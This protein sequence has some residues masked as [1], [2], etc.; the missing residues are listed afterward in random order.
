[1]T[2]SFRPAIETI[3]DVAD[4][5]LKAATTPL[6][7]SRAQVGARL[8]WF[9]R[10]PGRFAPDVIT[11]LFAG[12][13]KRLDRPPHLVVDPFAGTGS[14]MVVARQLGVPS[15]GIELSHLGTLVAQ[16]RLDP[17][18]HPQQ[19][20]VLAEAWARE[21][22]GDGSI[23][24]E[25]LRSWL[26]ESNTTAVGGYLGRIKEVSD[27]RLARLMTLAVSAALRPS[28]RWLPGSIK[29]QIAKDRTCPPIGPNLVRA[30]R[31]L[32]RDC[33]L[34]KPEQDVSALVVCGDARRL[35]VSCKADALITS[36]PYFVS[37]DYF[38]VQRLSYLAFGWPRWKDLQ[39]GRRYGIPADGDGFA[40][41]RAMR[42]WYEDD[43]RSEHTVLGRALRA[44][45]NDI[46]EHVRAAIRVLS[47]GAVVAYA[48]ASSTRMGRP[49]NLAAAL[50]SI[51]EEAG[52]DAVETEGRT[53]SGR[54]ILPAARDVATG[55]FTSGS[56]PPI[57]ERIVY[58][59]VPS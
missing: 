15:V 8:G 43:Y 28:S 13:S 53:Q 10:Y 24:D 42:R 41:P 5:T 23:L 20:V 27:P 18:E 2:E 45:L 44:Y 40:P 46:A 55:R 51:L 9:H 11:K 22:A 58:A 36:P 50:K 30:A 47:P 39:V 34:E 59:R 4:R 19:A 57:A 32:S 25:E 48:I 52:F 6:G 54:R 56:A 38:D 7:L 35:P 37:Y 12:V 3:Q 16:V 29:P 21:S 31:W 26:G 1:M 14:T 33:A 49:F 17:P